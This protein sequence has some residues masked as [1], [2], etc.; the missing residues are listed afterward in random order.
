MSKAVPRRVGYLVTAVLVC[1]FASGQT[2]R[3]VRNTP[4]PL[5]VIIGRMQQV[6]VAG[7]PKSLSVVREYLFSK[8]TS[9][10]IFSKVLARL[11]Y[12]S[13]GLER[14][15]IQQTIGSSRGE[16]IVKRILEHEVVTSAESRKLAVNSENYDFVFAGTSFFDGERCYL[17]GLIPKRQDPGL[18]AG[19]AWVDQNSFRLL[20]IEGKMVKT[21][22]W[23]LKT[24]SVEITFGDV[25]GRWLQTATRASADVRMVG[26]RSLNS[27]VV[28]S[29][30]GQAVMTAEMH[31]NS[32]RSLA[33]PPIPAE[34]L[35]PP[36]HRE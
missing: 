28:S 36:L 13:G 7:Q 35:L 23:W 34:V 3:E 6:R 19:Q 26:A 9:S 18:I 4:P 2:S 31:G 22:S 15:S 29:E 16:D 8:A 24:V 21:P 33:P 30:A 12:D 10:D 27:Q 5:D 14:Y 20:H 32:R 17:L 11:D 1:S 25:G